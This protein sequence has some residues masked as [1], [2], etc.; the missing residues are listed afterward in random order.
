MSSCMSPEA[1]RSGAAAADAGVWN[2][3]VAARHRSRRAAS[4]RSGH[5]PLM[6]AALECASMGVPVFPC[7]SRKAPCWKAEDGG[8]GFHDASTDPAEVRR[9]FGHPAAKL[10]GMRTGDASG[11]DVVDLDYRHGAKPF[12][13]ANFARWPETRVHETMS[14]GRHHIFRHAP[15]VRCSQGKVH[16]GVDV[17][18]DGGTDHPAKPWLHRS[19]GCRAERMARV[20]ARPRPQRAGRRSQGT[21]RRE[22]ETPYLPPSDKRLAGFVRASLDALK[23]EAVEGRKHDVLL[24]KAIL[25]GG[26]QQQAGLSDDHLVEQMLAMLP[27]TVLDWRRAD[28]TARD[29]LAM[30]RERP[31]RLEDR[32]LRVVGHRRSGPPPHPHSHVEG[33]EPT[34]ASHEPVSRVATSNDNDK[35]AAGS[36]RATRRSGS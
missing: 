12:E 18:A 3:R 35:P 11:L 34:P 13:E 33:K 16:P 22:R 17:R 28:K 15:G 6:Q 2:E 9:L 5:T 4:E 21:P 1:T 29:G 20:V 36:R 32:P 19:L 8:R 14:G 23:A 31:I 26:V 27:D 25:L 10:I 30:G 24:R 7:S